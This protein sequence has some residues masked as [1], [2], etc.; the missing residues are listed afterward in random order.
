M[1]LL[2]LAQILDCQSSTVC[3]TKEQLLEAIIERDGEEF[4]KAA[5]G[6]SALDGDME[7]VPTKTNPRIRDIA[8]VIPG[9]APDR[10]V[11]CRY[12]VRYRSFTVYEIAT[13]KPIATNRWRVESYK[14]M[15]RAQR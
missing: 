15:M 10:A 3:P 12:T 13:L 6:L 7:L 4:G 11:D 9:D 8:C 5:A 2:A 14:S 1:L